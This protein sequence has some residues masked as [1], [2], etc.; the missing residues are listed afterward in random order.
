MHRDDQRIMSRRQLDG[1]AREQLA[2]IAVGHDELAATLQRD[3]PEN[4]FG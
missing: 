4:E 1:A 3:Q 2:G